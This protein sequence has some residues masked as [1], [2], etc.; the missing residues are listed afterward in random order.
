MFSGRR[1][2]LQ[3]NEEDGRSAATRLLAR[4]HDFFRATAVEAILILI[5]PLI[6]DWKEPLLLIEDQVPK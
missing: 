3:P 4:H 6:R 2:P 1:Q 5:P